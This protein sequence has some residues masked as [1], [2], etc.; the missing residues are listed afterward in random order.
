MGDIPKCCCLKAPTQLQCCKTLPPRSGGL[1]QPHGLCGIPDRSVAC[2]AVRTLS[3]RVEPP[4]SIPGIFELMFTFLEPPMGTSDL[5]EAA[6]LTSLFS[7]YLPTH[8]PHRPRQSSLSWGKS[9]PPP[10]AP[11]PS[12]N[13]HFGAPVVTDTP[14]SQISGIGQHVKFT[15]S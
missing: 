2:P 9:T 13:L 3:P 4:V 14:G 5:I 8:H 1:L 15:V 7:R 12:P 6:A 11:S 10:P